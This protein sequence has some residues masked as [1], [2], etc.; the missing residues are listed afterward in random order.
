MWKKILNSNNTVCPEHT[1]KASCKWWVLSLLQ[2][3]IHRPWY[4][5]GDFTY[6]PTSGCLYVHFYLVFCW[7]KHVGARGKNCRILYFIILSGEFLYYF[8]GKRFANMNILRSKMAERREVVVIFFLCFS[9]V[10]MFWK[11]CIPDVYI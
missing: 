7:H 5:S 6:F 4:L 1:A 8:W 3:L 9:Q 2:R 11:V 10:K